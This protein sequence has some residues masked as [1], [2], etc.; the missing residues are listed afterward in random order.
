LLEYALDPGPMEAGWGVVTV[1]LLWLKER[2]LDGRYLVGLRLTDQAGRTWGQRDSEPMA[3]LSPFSA[4]REGEPV[5]DHHGLLVP[6]GTPPGDYQ[7]RLGVYRATDKRGLT[8]LDENSIPQGT[9]ALLGVVQVVPPGRQPPVE[10]LAIA[11]PLS[12]DLADSE[13]GPI[14]RLLGYSLGEG[15][16][17]PGQAL[18]LT[19]FWQALADVNRDY[20]VFVQLQD[21]KGKLWANRET[22]PVDSSYPTAGWQAD[23]LVRDPHDFVVPA[24]MPDGQY[25]LVVGLYR[26]TDRERLAV[27]AGPQR[28]RDELVLTEVNILGREHD[29]LKPVASHSLQARF[30][31]S[32]V[33]IGYDLE[34]R[35]AR[36]G[37]KLGLTLYW[38]ALS[39]VD[40]SYTVFV[41]LLDA[42]EVIQGWGD[43]LPGGGTLPTTSWLAGEYL[44]D[45]HEIAIEP[46]APSGEYLIEVGLYEA[47]SGARLPVLD[48]EG[49]VQGD[50]VLLTDTISILADAD[51][52][53]GH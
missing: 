39:S 25:H 19:L 33:L 11:H 20:I 46:E 29:Y 10:A 34:A 1:D 32:I 17:K 42:D 47:I 35:Q 4:W 43:S 49:Q 48:E 9:E 23:Q 28:G 37:D 38:Q 24:A 36:P 53:R 14:L 15:P 51:G 41:H 44:R 26:A 50:Q 45:R 2:G 5:P 52:Q 13:E 16:L 3:G 21:E 30:G 7:L 31:E 22:S 6:A 12:A 8:V 27:V 18:K 40:K